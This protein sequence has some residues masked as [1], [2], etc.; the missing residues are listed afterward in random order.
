MLEGFRSPL[1]GARALARSPGCCGQ[2]P[3][4]RGRNAV[5]KVLSAFHF[6]AHESPPCAAAAGAAGSPGAEPPLWACGRLAGRREQQ[7]HPACIPNCQ[8]ALL[9]SRLQSGLGCVHSAELGRN[10]AFGPN[11][12][13]RSPPTEILLQIWEQSVSVS[14]PSHGPDTQCAVAGGDPWVWGWEGGLNLS[15]LL[16]GGV[17]FRDSCSLPSLL[18]ISRSLEPQLLLRNL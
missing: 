3:G 18:C 16:S 13:R 11:S 17:L 5:G 14:F 4:E 7:S 1:R 10:F 2:R 8:E 12:L 9:G 15:P 6:P